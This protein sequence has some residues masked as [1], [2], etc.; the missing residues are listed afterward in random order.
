[1]Y[2]SGRVIVSYVKKLGVGKRAQ[3]HELIS[4]TRDPIGP[5]TNFFYKSMSMQDFGPV[6]HNL[7]AVLF[8][9]KIY[10]AVLKLL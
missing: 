7:R 4:R 2:V 9:L 8:M 6:P 3:V 5:Q 1:L 10:L